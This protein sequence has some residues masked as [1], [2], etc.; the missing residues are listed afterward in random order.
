MPKN[1]YS[2]DLTVTIEKC[3]CIGIFANS[4][5]EAIDLARIHVLKYE[6]AK[7]VEVK[8]CRKEAS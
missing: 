3:K 5:Q 4:K 8:D 1:R 6:N 2:V 7:S